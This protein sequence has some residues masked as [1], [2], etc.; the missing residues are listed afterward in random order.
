MGL[1][2]KQQNLDS[3]WEAIYVLEARIAGLELRHGESGPFPTS[4]D[5]TERLSAIERRVDSLEG[6]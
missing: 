6:R 5:I 4:S 2:D 1:T 3:I